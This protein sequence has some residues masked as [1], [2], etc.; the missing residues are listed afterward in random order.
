MDD[1]MKTKEGLLR[2]YEMFHPRLQLFTYTT[3]L[4]IVITNNRSLS[5]KFQSHLQSK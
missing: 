3:H 2:I 1:L 5:W 4:C